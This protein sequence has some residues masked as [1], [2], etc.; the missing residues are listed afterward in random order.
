MAV[1]GLIPDLSAALTA[2][3]GLGAETLKILSR[4]SFRIESFFIP[5]SHDPSVS[6]NSRRANRVVHTMRHR[7][8]PVVGAMLLGACSSTPKDSTSKKE[9]A[10]STQTQSLESQLTEYR[11]GFT[12][13][14]PQDLQTLFQDRID[15]LDRSGIVNDALNVGDQAPDFTLNDANGN[16]V[17]LTE[18][19]KQGPVI[20]NWYRGG[21]C[22]YCNLTLRSYQANLDQIAQAGATFVAITPETPDNSLTTTQKN[23]LEYPVLS[24]PGNQVARQFGLVFRLQDDLA[25]IYNDR[26]DLNGYNGDSSNELPLAATYVIDSDGT[27]R[28]A[29]LSPDYRERAEPSEVIAATQS[30][31][32]TR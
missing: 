16:P 27:I 14:A 19:L 5:R 25:E 6:M 12:K 32:G 29:F 4:G 18:L 8:I 28:F 22:P 15:D 26:F 21:W 17:Q 1:I 23:E 30:L 31:A 11:A 20:L 7:I 2:H 13:S 3:P 9:Q 24:D 10:V